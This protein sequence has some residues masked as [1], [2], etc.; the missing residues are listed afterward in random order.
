MAFFFF[1][2]QLYIVH[3]MGMF[4]NHKEL[5]DLLISYYHFDTSKVVNVGCAKHFG[6][7]H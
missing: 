4:V 6:T 5:R 3:F 1:V 2:L 7:K